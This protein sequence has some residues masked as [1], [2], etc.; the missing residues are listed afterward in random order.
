[1]PSDVDAMGQDKH[2]PVIGQ[3]K[4]NRAKHLAY[5]AIFV[6]FVIV[7]YIGLNAAV[8]HFDKAPA[9]DKASAPWAQPGAPQI[10]LGGFEPSHSHQRGPTHFQ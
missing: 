3:H 9:H 8:N 4:P 5:Y 2:R 10:P 1:M 6:A 7:A